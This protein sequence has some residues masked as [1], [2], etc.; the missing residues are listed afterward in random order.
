MGKQ[1]RLILALQQK[2]SSGST[3]I[4]VLLLNF[5]RKYPLMYKLTSQISKASLAIGT[6]SEPDDEEI[7]YLILLIQ[8]A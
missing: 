5:K 2:L 6:E 3:S 4:N 8:K 7:N 1:E